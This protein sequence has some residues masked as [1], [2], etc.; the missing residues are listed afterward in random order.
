[1]QTIEKSIEV[2]API[3]AVYNQ[4]TH[5]EQFPQFMDGVEQVRQMDDKHLHWIAKVAGKRKEWDA[6]ILEQVPDERIVWQSTSGARNAGV[7]HFRPK[8]N[9]HTLVSLRMDYEPDG[10][11]ESIGSALGMLGSR[12]EGDLRHFRDYLHEHSTE[13]G[14]HAGEIRRN[15]IN[16]GGTAGMGI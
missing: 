15:D 11:M 1:M 3:S 9:D 12:I 2:D 10:A 7:V 8:G 4:W 16:R 14:S 6:E 13:T 5:F